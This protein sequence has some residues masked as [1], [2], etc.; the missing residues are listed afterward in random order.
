MLTKD[1]SQENVLLSNRDGLSRE[2]QAIVYNAVDHQLLVS[3]CQDS[4][5]ACFKVLCTITF[6]HQPHL[7]KISNA[8]FA[9]SEDSDQPRHPHSLIR[10]LAVRIL[11]GL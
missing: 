3:N 5:I 4:W 8:N 11:L 1:L 7:N 6:T 10:V 2:P 9:P